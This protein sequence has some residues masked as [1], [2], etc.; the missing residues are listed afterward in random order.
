VKGYA[1]DANLAFIPIVA[2]LNG[3]IGG[4]KTLVL[5]NTS[6]NWLS[7]DI[8]IE[9]FGSS[10]YILQ[11]EDAMT[12]AILTNADIKDITIIIE[13]IRTNTENSC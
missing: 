2:R 13:F 6:S 11:L 4:D 5:I 12:G 10:S 9:I 8:P 3:I 7:Q 1:I